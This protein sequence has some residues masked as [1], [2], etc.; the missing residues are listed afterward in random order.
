MKKRIL[1][2]S[3]ASCLLA[4]ANSPAAEMQPAISW[5]LQP[6]QKWNEA[7]FVGNS[8]L[9][10]IVYGKPVDEL[11]QLNHGTFWAG[12]PHDYCRNGAVKYLP[13]LRKLIFEGKQPAASKLAG[14]QFL[15][16]PQFQAAFQPLG[17][18]G[19]HLNL[20]GDVSDYRRELDMRK[21][22]VTVRFKSGGITFTR[23][24]FISH[25][26]GVMVVRVTASEPG[27]ISLSAKIDSS[28][29][30][31]VELQ[32]NDRLVLDGQWHEDGKPKSW[33][34]TWTEPG[35]RYSIGLKAVAE[36]G[37]VQTANKKIQIEGANSVTLLLGAGT[38][39]RDFRDISGDPAATWP[40][41]VQTAAEMGYAKLLDRHL[42]DFQ[43]LMDRVSLD[44]GGSEANAKPTDERLQAVQN[45]AEDPALAA[46]Y[47]QFGRYLLLSSSRPGSQPA[48]LQGI[49]NPTGS[50]CWGSKYTTNINLQMNYWPSEVANLSECSMPVY[51]MMDDLMIT[52]TK[53]AKEQYNCRGWVVHHNTDLWRGAAPVDGVWG[54]WPMG[55]AWL[56]RHPWDHYQFTGD[57]EF[58]EKRA[59]PQMRGAARFVL[60]F[61]IEA[62][63]G[64][65]VAGKLVTNPSQSPENAFLLQDGTRAKLTYGSTMDLMI[66][67]D[68]FE[69]CLA[70]IDVLGGNQFE[71]DLQKEIRSAL[72]RLAPVQIS[73]ASGRIQE[74]VEDYKEVEIGHRHVSHLFGLHPGTQIT[75]RGTPELMAAARK[76]LETRLANGG[77]GTGWS[78][79]W[80]INF[81]ARMQ[82]GT[83]AG[84]HLNLLF[85]KSTLPSLLDNCPPFQIDGNFGGAAGI[86]EMLLQS[87]AGEI[88]LL[89]ALPPAWKDGSVSGLRARGGF[90]IDFAWKDG[91]VTS[92]KIRSSS[93]RELKL[94]VNGKTETV[95]SEVNQSKKS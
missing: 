37:K 66:V 2:A 35:M 1:L 63:A 39:F 53:V 93:P 15:G 85:A 40:G 4:L 61:L 65:P 72:D 64:S 76:S 24:C 16:T 56:A 33:T 18:L 86:A 57:R 9:G 88:E 38:S 5:F 8:H 11:I 27:K 20:S 54:V 80:L 23:E 87:H 82:D 83:E 3:L 45:G 89:P 73:K 70:A 29:P 43:P 42:K 34:A 94:R 68:L 14:E 92:Y 52:G 32:G 49:W 46:L 60:D 22:V 44:L 84:R 28:Y 79:A 62:P 78:R 6:A 21:G 55:S 71:P 30:N 81:F 74:W 67:R 51:D 13:E 7:L 31:R 77:G 91:K 26:D 58:L 17:S 19:I 50:P 90:E 75:P 47:F 48:N 10:G 95:K 12:Q 59:W 41:L 25:P 69:N 36:G